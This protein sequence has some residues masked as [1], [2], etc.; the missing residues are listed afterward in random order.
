MTSHSANPPA[1]RTLGTIFAEHLRNTAHCGQAVHELFANIEEPA[2][3]IAEIGRL[4]DL[5]DDLT[6][7]AHNL[8]ASS[9]FSWHTHITEDLIKLLDDI[10]DGFNKTARLIDIFR[11][12]YIEQAAFDILADQRAM[13]RTLQPVL[14]RY[15]DNDLASLRACCAALK[16]KEE[17]VDLIYH[18]WRKKERRE[19]VLSLVEENN[20]TELFGVLE[21]TTDDIYHA[22]LELERIARYRG[23]SEMGA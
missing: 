23:R 20:W 9:P 12:A 4:E 3:H 11:P 2:A 13:M 7:E 14:D 15:P 8:L 18:E 19:Q 10:V 1:P 17:N 6:A 16:E 21:Q 5:G 22:A